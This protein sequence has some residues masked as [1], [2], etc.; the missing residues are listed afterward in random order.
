MIKYSVGDIVTVRDDLICGKFYSGV[1]FVEGMKKYMGKKFI[2][3]SRY[4]KHYYL[5]NS[6]YCWSA[7]MFKNVDLKLENIDFDDVLLKKGGK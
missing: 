1:S 7:A 4:D 5:D 3:T 2:I 6:S